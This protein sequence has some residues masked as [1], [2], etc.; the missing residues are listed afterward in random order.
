MDA[1]TPT[2]ENTHPPHL[3]TGSRP[4]SRPTSPSAA[5]RREALELGNAFFPNRPPLLAEI[6]DWLQALPDTRFEPMV[7]YDAR[8]LCRVA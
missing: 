5:A 1:Q 3:Q 8:F 7:D 6:Q 2:L 4:K